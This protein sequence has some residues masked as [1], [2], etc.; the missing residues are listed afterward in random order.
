[1][2]F[3]NF[4]AFTAIK[5]IDYIQIDEPA[6]PHLDVARRTTRVD[7]VHRGINLPMKYSGKDVVV[8]VIDFGF[9]Y[10]H[11]SFYDTLHN[12][13]RVK[14]VWELNTKGT[15]LDDIEELI[16]KNRKKPIAIG[17]RAIIRS[18]KGHKYWSNF[19]P[20][21]STKIET[22]AKDLHSILFDLVP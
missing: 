11:P 17:A 6:Q 21:F 20:E 1:M 8:G 2:P 22:I 14:R 5:G 12:L 18:G 7:S 3:Q 19:R 16:L 10:N 15:P 13:Y 4:K 9:D